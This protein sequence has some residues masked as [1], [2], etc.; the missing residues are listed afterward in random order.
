MY[1]IPPQRML[2]FCNAINSGEEPRKHFAGR[3]LMREGDEDKPT[4]GNPEI[5]SAFT[6]YILSS[7]IRTTVSDCGVPFPAEKNEIGTQWWESTATLRV[8]KDTGLLPGMKFHLP[9]HQ[10]YSIVVTGVFQ[11]TCDVL[12]RTPQPMQ[13]VG[14]D[15]STTVSI[16]PRDIILFDL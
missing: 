8:G 3:F 7:P 1:L 10:L 2:A 14:L 5:P 12:I 16:D 15:I 4:V 11:D 9:P 13:T 6:R